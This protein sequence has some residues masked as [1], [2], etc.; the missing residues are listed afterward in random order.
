MQQS[1]R[2]STI[3]AA[4]AIVLMLGAITWGAWNARLASDLRVELDLEKQKVETLL[5]EKVQAEKSLAGIE[6][7]LKKVNRE[8]EVLRRK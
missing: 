5:F 8:N 3:A 7:E 2:S 4:V 6:S 1:N